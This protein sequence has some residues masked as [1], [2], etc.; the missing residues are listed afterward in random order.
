MALEFICSKDI[1]Q[2]EMISVPSRANCFRTKSGQIRFFR[3]NPSLDKKTQGIYENVKEIS[4]EQFERHAY[5]IDYG[6]PTFY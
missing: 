5:N 2:G 1:V 3:A 4:F 6:E